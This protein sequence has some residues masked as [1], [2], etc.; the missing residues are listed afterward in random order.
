MSTIIGLAIFALLGFGAY[1]LGHSKGRLS[2]I[3]SK[4]SE[5]LDQVKAKL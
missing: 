5:L 3:E 1:Y 2:V 4:L